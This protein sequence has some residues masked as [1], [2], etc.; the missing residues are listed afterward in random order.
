AHRSATFDLLRTAVEEDMAAGR[1]RRDDTLE[2]ALT[3]WAHA[4]GLISMFTLGRFGDDA[5]AFR[6]LYAR[7][8]RR[9]I[10][11]LVEGGRS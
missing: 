1:M 5:A 11:G 9:L 8:M 7:S 6:K 10:T 2:T 3:I 4:H